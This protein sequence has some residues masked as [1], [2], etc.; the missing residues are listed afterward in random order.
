M[1]LHG[2]DE[3]GSSLGGFASGVFGVV[4]CTN[5]GGFGAGVVSKGERCSSG[6]NAVPVSELFSDCA[7]FLV[8]STPDF[9]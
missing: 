1:M 6:S 7:A 5:G 2:V 9:E 8:Q 4:G 3:V